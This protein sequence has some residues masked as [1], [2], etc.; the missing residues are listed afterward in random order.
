MILSVCSSQG[1]AYTPVSLPPPKMLNNPFEARAQ[2]TLAAQPTPPRPAAGSGGKSTWSERQA[3]ARKRANEEGAASS[4]VN[5]L[6]PDKPTT[7]V[8]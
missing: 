8:C 1:T 2:A 3:F 6:N 4:E 5:T 7:C